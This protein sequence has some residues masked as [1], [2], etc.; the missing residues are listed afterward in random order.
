M[1]TTTTIKIDGD[2]DLWW[3]K[4]I[5]KW[6]IGSS[7]ILGFNLG[8]IHSVQDSACPTSDNLF[9]YADWMN[10]EWTLAPINSF[11]IQCI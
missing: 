2:Q 11:S 1:R 8:Y 3:D 7:R 6:M 9:K 5:N 4:I 10:G